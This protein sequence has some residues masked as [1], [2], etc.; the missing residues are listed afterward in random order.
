[1]C[2]SLRISAVLVALAASALDA[3]APQRL[4]VKAAR[5][6]D[7]RGGTYR[8]NQGIWIEAGRIRQVGPFDEVR[9]AAPNDASVFDLG[10][11]TVLPGLIDVHAHLLSA[12]D[13]GLDPVDNLILTLTKESA[14]KRALI[15]ASTAREMV[16]GGF[17]TVRNVGHSGIDGDVALRDAIRR[18]ALP[19]PRIAAA[20][21][22]IT[23]VGGQALGSLT[24]AAQALVDQD[25]L[26]VATPA[27]GRRAVLENLRVGVDVIK[28]VADDGPRV[29]DGETMKAIVDEAH[30]GG[31]RVA[32]HATSKPGIQG[33]IDGGPDSIEHGDA[34]TDEQFQ[35][36]RAK[37]IVLV[38]TVWPNDLLPISRTLAVIPDLEA[39]KAGYVKEEGAK[40]ERAR[41]AG[42]TIAFG[43]DM[44]FGHA[45]KTRAQ[46]TRGVL[47]ALQ[48]SFGMSAADA[49]RTAT[50]TAAELL[51]L[52]N[53]TGTIEAG[54]FADLIAVDGDPLADLR[55]LEKVV[56]VM[57]AGTVMRDERTTNQP[58]SKP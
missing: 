18:G 44:W 34:A 54:A 22:K 13:P 1:M 19:G 7:V 15:G 45:G 51:K 58:R 3:Q 49:L 9:R 37:G 39:M 36:M 16:D 10:R 46:T 57:R 14:A 5:V 53:V 38:P 8:G 41:K 43:S 24:T 23:P 6:V 29:I 32:V 25:F 21:R 52:P 47:Q 42:V 50:V 20:G 17:T 48:T 26:P 33:A 4:L 31:A 40:L 28:V 35:A 11:A 56:F 55:D 12:M 2:H 30:R 27:N